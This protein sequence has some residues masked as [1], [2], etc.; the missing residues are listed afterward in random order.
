[1]KGYGSQ[2][3][4]IA[5]ELSA[6]QTTTTS[7]WPAMYCGVPKNRAARSA[8]RPNA[9][10]PNAPWCSSRLA[11]PRGYAARRTLLAEVGAAPEPDEVPAAG[12][13]PAEVVAACVDDHRRPDDGMTGEA[14][15]AIAADDIACDRHMPRRA[16]LT[17]GE[18]DP[19]AQRLA[20]AVAGDRVFVDHDPV[21]L[22]RTADVRIECQDD[23]RPRVVGDPVVR[24]PK[25]DDR[26]RRPVRLHVDPRRGIAMA[27]ACLD[28]VVR[29]RRA[30][31]A[32]P[33]HG[34]PS[35]ARDRQD[36]ARAAGERRVMDP[37][38]D[39]G[40]PAAHECIV[41]RRAGDR[42]VADLDAGTG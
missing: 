6:I 10:A 33:R 9:S 37:D 38:V 8:R 42:H 17:T 29:V 23:S 26:I 34:D 36:V 22:A 11:T 19:A 3:A 7:D 16:R 13:V 14:K 1:M 40:A 18:D 30:G 21:G 5:I 24:D 28:E 39:C 15:A 32:A 25:I 27:A 35:S 41:D 12:S 2:C 31:E 4:T 20:A